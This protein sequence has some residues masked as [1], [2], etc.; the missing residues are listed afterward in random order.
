[1]RR[2]T[3]RM[4]SKNQFWLPDHARPVIHGPKN[5]G[6]REFI[7]DSGMEDPAGLRGDGSNA[8]E[9]LFHKNTRNRGRVGGHESP[10]CDASRTRIGGSDGT[11]CK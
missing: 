7:E 10:D 2:E 5:Q 8:S 6:D 1:M 4:Y 3:A 11:I 9:E